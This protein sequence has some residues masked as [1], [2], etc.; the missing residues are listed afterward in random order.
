MPLLKQV[1]S[2]DPKGLNLRYGGA[3]L[4]ILALVWLVTNQL[5]YER[6][7]L[8]LVFAVVFTALSDPGGEFRERVQAMAAVGLLGA[9][10]TALGFYVGSQTWGWLVFAIFAVT[11]LAGLAIRFGTRRFAS[12][13]LLNVWF[14]VVIS[15]AD[16][17]HGGAVPASLASRA[18]STHEWEQALAWLIGSVVWIAVMCIVWLASGSKWR[19]GAVMEL[20]GGGV[21]PVEL[22]R[23]VVAFVLIR[24]V[25]V[26]ASA[27]IAF[28]LDL[29]AADWMVVAT[30]VIM[31]PSLEQS[32][33][34]GRQRLIGAALGALLAI[35]ILSAVDNRDTLAWMIILLAATAVA[36]H[37]VNYALYSAAIAGAVLIAVD[38][39]HPA[40]YAAEGRRV[41]WTFVGVAIG[42]VVM[43]IAERLQQHAAK[44]A[45]V[46]PAPA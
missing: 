16:V 44:S 11:V 3:S 39:P 19:P 35:P 30:I 37:G 7:F 4:V 8:T 6:Y 24:A 15:V 5:D 36:I 29:S 28:G 10:L 13:L 31:K 12:A 1:F 25:A 32:R 21:A 20:P 27:A 45:P 40:S 46:S 18:T 34:A 2:L 9:A 33:L 38:L 23:R 22:T 41:L 43:L 42:V 17:L 14:I 26:S